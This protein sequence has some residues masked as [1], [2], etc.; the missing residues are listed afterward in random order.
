MET[1]EKIWSRLRAQINR[2]ALA[3]DLG[4]NKVSVHLWDRVPAERLVAV[5]RA[6]NIPRQQLRPDLYAPPP[7]QPWL[8]PWATLVPSKKD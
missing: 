6:L 8:E 7:D 3:D 1:P 5:E 2:A 4:I